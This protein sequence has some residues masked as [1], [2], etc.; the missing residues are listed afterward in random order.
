MSIETRAELF[1][2]QA[3]GAVVARALA[4]MRRAVRPGVTTAAL[5]AVAANLFEA[6]G[7]RSGPR[8]D[9]DFPGVTCISVNDEAIHGIP[10][11]R[12]LE[13]GDL[14]KL[15][16]TAELNGFYADACDTV[17]VGNGSPLGER[18]AASARRALNA[19][20]RVATAGSPLNGI[21][22]AVERSVA[23]DG[24]SVCAELTGHGIGRRIHEEPTVANT[25]LPGFGTPL[26]EG[27][28][29]TIEPVIAAGAGQVRAMADG[30][31]VCTADRSLSAHVE[32]TLV[33]RHGRPLVLTAP[34]V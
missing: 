22:A 13:P 16:V 32:H 24:F 17:S 8:L 18:L 15:D 9:Y 11:P 26:R 30:W 33:I 31:T 14:V 29:L 25:W 6:T 2:M 4:E 21:G 28:V 7:A 20:M 34:P 1:G 27:T 23:A 12:E 5:D 19:A 10:G 3:A